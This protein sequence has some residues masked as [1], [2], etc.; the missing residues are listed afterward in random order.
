MGKPVG[1]AV[2]IGDAEGED[3][4]VGEGNDVDEGLKVGLDVE[5]RAAS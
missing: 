5:G 4:C 1:L 2:A 3:V